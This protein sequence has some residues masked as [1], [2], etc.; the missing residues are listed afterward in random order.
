MRILHKSNG[1]A[2]TVP[3]IAPREPIAPRDR[4][5]VSEIEVLVGGDG[6]TSAEGEAMF[7][8]G[9]LLGDGRNVVYSCNVLGL[10]ICGNP[11]R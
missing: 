8:S 11:N 1:C 5:E 9:L 10:P 2:R 3:G 6:S 4:Q 7:A